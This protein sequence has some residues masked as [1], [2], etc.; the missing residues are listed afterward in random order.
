[1]GSKSLEIYRIDLS[2]NVQLVDVALMVDM[3]GKP[4]P[5]MPLMSSVIVTF[6][7]VIKAEYTKTGYYRVRVEEGRR[8][9]YPPKA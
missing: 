8:I 3:R 4:S 5:R 6:E 7:S 9:Y 1:M 2:G